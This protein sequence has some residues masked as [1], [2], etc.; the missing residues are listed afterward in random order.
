MD[1]VW[2]FLDWLHHTQNQFEVKLTILRL[3]HT[4][5][6]VKISLDYIHD[7]LDL[8]FYHAHFIF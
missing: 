5:C 1:Q 8:K 6:E 3:A 4:R 7:S 2:S